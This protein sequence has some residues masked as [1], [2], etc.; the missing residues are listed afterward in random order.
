MHTKAGG[1]YVQKLIRSIRRQAKQVLWQG[2][3]PEPCQSRG[4]TD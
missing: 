1:K 4:Y 2:V 3:E